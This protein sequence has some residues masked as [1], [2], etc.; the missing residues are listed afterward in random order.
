MARKRAP[1]FISS[2]AAKPRLRLPGPSPAS[3][4]L[5]AGK[6]LRLRCNRKDHAAIGRLA[7][8]RDAV[9][10]MIASNKGR[11][12]KLLPIRHSRM[13]ES[14]FTFFRGAAAVQA[15]DLAHAPSS[16]IATQCCGDAHL[17]NF[18]G[19]ATP[20]RRFLFDIND[21]DETF[22]APFEWDLKRLTTSFVLAAR[23][24][25][26]SD[27]H[28][29]DIATSAARGYCGE[30]ARA[31][32]ENTLDTWYAA[33]TWKDLLRDVRDDPVVFDRLKQITVEAKHHTSEYVFHKLAA[34]KGGK[35]SL[36]DQPPLLYHPPGQDLMAMAG[37]FFKA[38]LKTLRWSERLMF[39][40]LRFIDAAFKVVGVG[41]VGTRCYVVLMLGEQN[42]P[43]FLQIKEARK[44]VLAG[45]AGPSPWRDEGERVVVGQRLLQAASD[46][47]LG[48]AKG[49]EGHFY[50]VRQL[51]DMKASVDIASMNAHGL[52]LYASLCG[53]TLA[54]AHAKAGGASRIAGYLGKSKAFHKALGDYAIAYADLAEQD[55]ESFRRAA[56]DGRIK[57]E[58]S[59]A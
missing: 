31:A 5:N 44:S 53:Q 59:P 35:I 42:E 24:R 25:G 7:S 2:V 46:I 15:S 12:E 58:T 1:E 36:H 14:P 3:K 4:D 11:V 9:A 13:L 29:R 22:R 48:W 33:V 56:A 6:S 37:R 55:F 38:Y 27:A 50:Y 10:M 39:A 20:E 17:M 54:R 32:A 26:I 23:W 49:P 8:R 16:G 52:D 18:G 43:V 30:I 19:F 40:R 28:A 34:L 57:T 45:H 51:R 21:F 41:S 47:F